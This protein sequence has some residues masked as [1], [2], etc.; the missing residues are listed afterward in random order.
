MATCELLNHTE[1]PY[2]VAVSEAVNITKK[3][4]ADQGHKFV[5]GV[6]TQLIIQLRSLE[7]S[8]EKPL[9]VIPKISTKKT[10][11][12]SMEKPLEASPKISTKKYLKANTKKPLEK[13]SKVITKK[14]LK[15]SLNISTK[16]T[17]EASVEAS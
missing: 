15:A 12:V 10:L 1:T 11:E 2:K 13:S 7:V 14:S 17:L 9:D 5:N 16:K 6:M 4:G 3:F 8:A